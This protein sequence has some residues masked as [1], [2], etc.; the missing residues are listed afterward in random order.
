MSRITAVR[1]AVVVLLL[2]LG[3]AAVVWVATYGEPQSKGYTGHVPP[4]APVPAVRSPDW[5]T[6]LVGLIGIS[7]LG[8]AVL[9]FRRR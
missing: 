7:A 3:A 8:G 2:G 5:G 6:P 4:G 9:V 1:L